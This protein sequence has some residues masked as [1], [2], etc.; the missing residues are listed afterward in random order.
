MHG[1]INNKINQPPASGRLF[2][3]A[4]QRFTALVIES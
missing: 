1:A 4:M 3:R 2:R